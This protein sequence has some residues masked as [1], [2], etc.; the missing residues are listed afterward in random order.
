MPYDP[1]P[2]R[3]P[4]PEG[5][6]SPLA[7]LLALTLGCLLGFGCAGVGKDP[8]DPRAHGTGSSTSE[9]PSPPKEW[10]AM[11]DAQAQRG[12]PDSALLL[13][14][15]ITDP[16]ASVRARAAFTLGLDHPDAFEVLAALAGTD[17]SPLVR[18]AA[19]TAA[20]RAGQAS[21]PEEAGALVAASLQDQ[22]PQV[23]ASAA[24]A[25][26]LIGDLGENAT[27]LD[28]ALT[29]ATH[30]ADPEVRW[31][32]LFSISRRGK[33]SDLGGLQERALTK[34]AAAMERL[35]ATRG[36]TRIGVTD[37][38]VTDSVLKALASLTHD[39]DWRIAMEAALGL[40]QGRGERAQRA[41]L[42]ALGHS[43]FHVRQAAATGLRATKGPLAD[44]LAAAVI[45]LRKDPS[46]SVRVAGILAAAR[47]MGPRAEQ[48]VRAAA[49]HEDPRMRYGSLAAALEISPDLAL[50]LAEELLLDPELRVA[51]AAVETL[52]KLVQDEA[53]GELVL[54]VLRQT[55]A[56]EDNGLRLAAVTSLVGQIKPE[57]LALFARCFFTS[58]GDI[59]PEV[60]FGIVHA[61]AQLPE[62][63]PLL[64]QAAQDNNPH[65]AAVAHAALLAQASPEAAGI[66]QRPKSQSPDLPDVPVWKEADPIVRLKTTKG[67]L[68]LQLFPREAPR[69]VASFLM[70]IERGHYDGLDFHRVVG[71]FV[72]QGGCYRGDGNGSG[73]GFDPLGA[74]PAEFNPV[75]YLTGT[76]GMPRNE[77]PDSGGGQIFITHRPTPH[78]D[79]RYTVF[80]QTLEGFDVLDVL[81]VGD[82]IVTIERLR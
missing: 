24:S 9:R 27:V 21:H 28:D 3:R 60:R 61:V 75:P 70:L 7:H 34:Q 22:A 63:A 47:V 48:M 72:V 56:N 33:V 55:L 50:E 37:S 14:T 36:L 68:L 69:H 78:L 6:I 32:A 53:I 44:S 66:L 45:A 40:G 49:K 31:R 58:K 13:R 46:P 73:T 38:G 74:L 8:R 2:S 19:V 67:D 5:S 35:Y 59:G 23:R 54:P 25:A 57:D 71:D 43:S 52:G 18:A 41:L 82:E 39:P 30:D 12:E 11:L 76:L 81:E 29:Q 4:L 16:E 80:G 79:G 65:V 1:Q 17:P 15:L 51:G 20:A 62:A 10:R 42:E 64:R 26:W 77:D